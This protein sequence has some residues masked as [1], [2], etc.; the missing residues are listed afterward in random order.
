MAD[1]HAIKGVQEDDVGLTAI[2]DEYFVQVPS[3]DPTVDH[4]GICMCRTA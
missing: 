2:V 4:H 1:A 3:Y